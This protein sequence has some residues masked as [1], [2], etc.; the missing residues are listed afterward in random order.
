M[1]DEYPTIRVGIIGTGQIG[2]H[3]L[4]MYTTKV[5]GVEVAAICDIRV[6][7]MERVGAKYNVES[8]YYSFRDLLKR[9]DIDA[10]D[11]CL[12]NNLHR[13]V[14]EL[15]LLAGKHVYCEK[16]MAGAYSD[17]LAMYETSKKVGKKLSIQLTTLFSKEIRAA[18]EL[19]EAGKLGNV[20]HARSTGFRRRG[21]PFVD[22]YGSMNFVRKEISAG[23]AMYDMGVYH[24]ASLLYLLNNPAI[25]RVT[26]KLYQET[27]IDPGRFAL[28][29][30]CVEELGVGFVR[31]V[32]NLSMDII[33]SWAIHLDRFEGPAVVGSMGGLRLD[34][35]GYFWSEGDLVMNA[36]GDLGDWA[37]RK[38]AIRENEEAY[39]GPQQHWIAALQGKV[40][41]LPTAELALNT[42]LISEGIYLSEQNGRELSKE[43]ILNLSKSRAVE[44]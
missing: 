42:M 38:G 17:A 23:G 5:S 15:A 31:F 3:H 8:Q 22:G 6:D 44:V 36:T 16:P 9:D 40:P 21:R 7:E 28:S 26:G 19:I 43:E 41:L 32:N 2:K 24:I 18:K 13:P 34:P 14:T 35:F 25:E 37:W 20:Y 33:E 4:D 30:Y 10:V 39:A 27:P 1:S 29:E 12:H 11:V